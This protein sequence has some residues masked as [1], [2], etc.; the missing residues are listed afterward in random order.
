MTSALA[1]RVSVV[2]VVSVLFLLCTVVSVGAEPPGRTL[3]VLVNPGYDKAASSLPKTPS[4]ELFKSYSIELS[5]LL[6][7]KSDPC[8][9]GPDRHQ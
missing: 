8:S 3:K 1:R 9:A 5:L 6:L 7:C 2:S 4:A